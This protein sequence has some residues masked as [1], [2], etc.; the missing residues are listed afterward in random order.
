[1]TEAVSRRP[2]VHARRNQ[3]GRVQVPEV[4][5]PDYRQAEPFDPR[6]M[7]AGAEHA[8]VQGSPGRSAEER[9]SVVELWAEPEFSLLPPHDR[10]SDALDHLIWEQDAAPPSGRLRLAKR[11]V[12][13]SRYKRPVN[14]QEPRVEVRRALWHAA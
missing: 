4:V 2:A 1:M 6:Q 10:R 3:I 12:G 14:V 9:T 5:Q 13:S 11:R 7:V 8:P